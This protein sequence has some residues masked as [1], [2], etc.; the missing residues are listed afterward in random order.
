MHVLCSQC[1]LEK[2]PVEFSIHRAAKN[3]LQ[4]ACKECAKLRR[5]EWS[6]KNAL[7]QKASF[8]ENYQRN[9][10]ERDAKSKDWNAQNIERRRE[11]A[12]GSNAHHA[13]RVKRTGA[14]W[15]NANRQLMRQRY[16]QR[17]AL[18]HQST[19]TWANSD[20]IAEFYATA[21]GLGM[22]TGDWYEVDH[23]VPLKSKIVCGLHCEANLQVLERRENRSKSNRYWPDMPA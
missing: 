11:I 13:D 10:S 16:A 21:D 5:V 12:R 14:L 18:K 4:S 19:P 7:R 17:R 8:A 9:K 2:L 1:K 15:R 3:G 22:H 6:A 20:K 23:I